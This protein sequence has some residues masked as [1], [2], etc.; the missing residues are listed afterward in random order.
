[1]FV[2]DLIHAAAHI[3][4]RQSIPMGYIDMSDQEI[5]QVLYA[6]SEDFGGTTYNLLTRQYIQRRLE[7]CHFLFSY[8][9]TT[10][11]I[12]IISLRIYVQD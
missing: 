8:I 6:V 12:V 1:M 11:G 5:E 4:I 3:W 7:T 2:N 10:I 9:C